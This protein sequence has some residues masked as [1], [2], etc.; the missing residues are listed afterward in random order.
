M[1]EPHVISALRKKRAELAGDIV[2]AQLRL[3]KLRDR[4]DSP[5]RQA[6]GR[7]AVRLRGM[8]AGYPQCATGRA[9][10][11]DNRPGSRAGRTGL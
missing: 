10:A 11:Y 9:R 8:H 3:G 5:R 4:E 7:Q 6:Q 2:T 1:A